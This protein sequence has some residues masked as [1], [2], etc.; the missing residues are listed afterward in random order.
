[1][2]FDDLRRL[3]CDDV[4]LLDA[5]PSGKVPSHSC[6]LETGLLL[7]LSKE[8]TDVRSSSIVDSSKIPPVCDEE[9]L[10]VSCDRDAY[11]KKADTLSAA[12]SVILCN[13]SNA[14]C[15]QD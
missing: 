2:S 13:N 14:T 5:L 4:L 11:N 1:M 7:V 10:S 8:Y 3:L 15:E 6:L 12:A 9:T